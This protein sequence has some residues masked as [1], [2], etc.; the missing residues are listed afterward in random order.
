MGAIMPEAA[1]FANGVMVR[2]QDLSDGYR[3]KG[4][5]HPSDVVAAIMAAGGNMSDAAR[6]DAA[7]IIWPDR[8]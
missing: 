3:T 2:M 8:F 5:G 6:R 4:G 7:V 1:A